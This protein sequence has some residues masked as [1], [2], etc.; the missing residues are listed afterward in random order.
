MIVAAPKTCWFKL[1]LA[2]PLLFLAATA[3]C[4]SYRPHP[5]S[6]DAIAAARDARTLD[7]AAV[8]RR[9]AEIAPVRPASPVIW[10][11]LSLFAAATLY[12]ADVAAARAA[13]DTAA[14]N[15]GVVRQ[16]PNMTLT[17][18][19][20]YARDPS[21]SSPWLFGGS[22]DIPLDIGGRRTTRV[23]TAD[24]AVLS[25]RY[26]VAEAIWSARIALRLALAQRMVADR[27][28]L[29]LGAL[30]QVRDRQFAAMARRVAAGEASRAELERV[31]ADGADAGRRLV[32]AQAQ[33]RAADRAIAAAIGVP[34]TAVTPLAMAWDGFDDPAPDPG[35]QVTTGLRL[36][37]LRSRADVLKAIVAYDQAESD[38]RGEVAKQFPAI[39][40]APGYT[41]ERGLVKVPFSLGLILPPLDLNRHAIAAAEARRAEA[42]KRLEAVIAS[43]E[44]AIDAA[45]VETRAARAALQRIRTVERVAADRLARQADRELAAGA[46]DRTDWAAAQ[47][48]AEQARTSEIDALARVHVADAALE[49]ALRRPL[50]GSET[51]IRTGRT[52]EQRR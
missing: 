30:A 26:D 39:S 33:H 8:G 48:G 45:L 50:E 43:A 49:D 15:V 24:L 52:G 38:L 19:S 18:T 9:V 36:E 17:L 44:A 5:V 14:A 7:Q 11:R 31:R 40:I 35:G 34:E 29:A 10:D 42:G 6:P 1:R 16:W 13:V 4:A 22:L 46:I 37:A 47:A 3:G 21:A 12:N 32:D 20:E 41:W 28:I 23:A 25:A 27:Q 2:V 51:M